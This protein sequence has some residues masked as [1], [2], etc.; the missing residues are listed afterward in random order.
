MNR[1]GFITAV[2]S[3]VVAAPLIARAQTATTVRRV[4]ILSSGAQHSP[5][6]FQQYYI[7]PLRDLG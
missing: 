4:D 6:L 5:T 1:R 7:A 2:A 3:G